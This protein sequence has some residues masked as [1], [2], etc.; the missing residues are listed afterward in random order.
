M[1]SVNA[2]IDAERKNAEEQQLLIQLLDRLKIAQA[3]W[4]VLRF[5]LTNCRW[6]LDEFKFDGFRFDGITS[7][8]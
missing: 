8:L 5:L 2:L 7:M 1:W 4:E 6:W 3:E